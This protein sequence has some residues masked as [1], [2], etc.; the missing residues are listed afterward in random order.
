MMF[1]RSFKLADGTLVLPC[2]FCSNPVFE[3]DTHTC[4][5]LLHAIEQTMKEQ[6]K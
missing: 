1:G 6:D 2:E 5:G 3:P 4:E